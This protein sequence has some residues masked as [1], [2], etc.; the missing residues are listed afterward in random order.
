MPTYPSLK[1]KPGRIMV[2]HAEL[3]ALAKEGK[4]SWE[5]LFWV[6]RQCH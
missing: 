6:K 2:A 5:P 3:L 4:F 1:P